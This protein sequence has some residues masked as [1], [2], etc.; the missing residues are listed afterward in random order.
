MRELSPSPSFSTILA[1]VSYRSKKLPLASVFPASNS[2]KR[3]PLPKKNTLSKVS[4][5]PRKFCQSTTL[6]HHSLLKKNTLFTRQFATTISQKKLLSI[7]SFPKK[8]KFLSTSITSGRL[9]S[10]TFGRIPSEKVQ[11]P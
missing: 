4:A 9:P 3:P 10:K 5:L 7:I 2:P 1:G 11:K 6:P 8:S